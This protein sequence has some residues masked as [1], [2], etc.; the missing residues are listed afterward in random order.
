MIL[1]VGL[2]KDA[3]ETSET[4]VSLKGDDGKWNSFV[5]TDVPAGSFIHIYVRSLEGDCT[6]DRMTWTPGGRE[7]TD[8]DKVTIS[9]AAVVGGKFS[10]SFES[11]AEFDYNLLTNAN[12]LINSWGVMTNEVGTGETITF[13]PQI[14][15]GQPQMFYRVDTIRKK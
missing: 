7:P 1:W 2:E 10:L 9:S 3:G 12:L 15:E 5:K 6:I 14:I 4:K 8:A 11:K 13:E